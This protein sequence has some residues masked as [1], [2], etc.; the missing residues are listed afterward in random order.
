MYNGKEDAGNCNI[1]CHWSI[2]KGAQNIARLATSCLYKST[3]PFLLVSSSV[4]CDKGGAQLGFFV[5][6]YLGINALQGQEAILKLFTF[7]IKN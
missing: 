1:A 3:G 6:L 2:P 4:Y 7:K 5:L